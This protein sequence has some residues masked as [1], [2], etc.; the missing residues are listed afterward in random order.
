MWLK[1]S[2]TASRNI[3]GT[4]MAD[5]IIVVQGYR[6]WNPAPSVET[7]KV[8]QRY[9]M[10]LCGILM[11]QGVKY[12]FRC[13]FGQ[14]EPYHIWAY[15]LVTDEVADRLVQ[16]HTNEL[17]SLIDE[18]TRDRSCVVALANDEKGILL[19]EMFGPIAYGDAKGTHDALRVLIERVTAAQLGLEALADEQQ[20]SARTQIAV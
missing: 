2:T 19:S 20:H 5:Y 3:Y 16:A 17:T 14:M 6:P 15:T 1:V 11:Q 9:S 7:V 13:L 4:A 18:A 10:P 8:L 12:L